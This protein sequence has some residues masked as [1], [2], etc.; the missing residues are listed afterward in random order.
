LLHCA[1]SQCVVKARSKIRRDDVETEDETAGHSLCW[2]IETEVKFWKECI[3]FKLLQDFCQINPVTQSWIKGRL[4]NTHSNLLHTKC[5]KNSERL[6]LILSY[7]FYVWM[8]KQYFVH[9]FLLLTIKQWPHMH[10]AQTSTYIH[11]AQWT[12]VF[13]Y[14]LHGN[15]T[16]R[17]ITTSELEP[18]MISVS[19]SPLKLQWYTQCT[20]THS[21]RNDNFLPVRRYASAGLCYSDVSVHHTPVLCLAE[22]KQDR[23]MYTIW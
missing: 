16:S 20:M 14:F 4:N 2:H 19:P 1:I 3:A 9:C 6:L 22:R 5:P 17:F 7:F 12:F 21:V 18:M 13:S 11:S 8:L 15:E 23:E 10:Y